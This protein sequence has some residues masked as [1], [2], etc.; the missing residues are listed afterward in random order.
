[1]NAYL[2]LFLCHHDEYFYGFLH[3]TKIVHMGL[4][5]YDAEQSV[6]IFIFFS[7]AVLMQKS[8][9]AKGK[10]IHAMRKSKYG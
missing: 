4:R 3:A 1:M 9:H 8:K 7:N 6:N 5:I 2:F 10:I